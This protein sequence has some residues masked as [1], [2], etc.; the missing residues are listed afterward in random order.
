MCCANQRAL[1][2]LA[3]AEYPPSVARVS[4]R[5]TIQI[6][7]YSRPVPLKTSGTPCFIGGGGGGGGPL[8]GVL[9]A[10]SS[11]SLC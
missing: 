10:N 7:K 6:R 8:A 11:S 3:H 5:L 9:A 1:R 2:T 4:S